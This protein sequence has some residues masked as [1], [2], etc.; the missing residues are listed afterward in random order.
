[1][2]MFLPAVPAVA[3]GFGAEPS[4]AQMSVTTYLLGVALGQF[5]WGPLSDRFG[6]KPVLVTGLALSLCASLAGATVDSLQQIL[7]LR[8]AQGLAMSSGPVIARSIVRDLYA[9]EQAAHLLSR[10][11]VVFGLV[12]VFAPLFGAQ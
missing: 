5:A 9:R 10:M 4:A 8:F 11:T 7:L 3:H 6:R 2:D 12:P 1:M